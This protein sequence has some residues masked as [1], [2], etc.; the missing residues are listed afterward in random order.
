[1]A[2][3]HHVAQFRDSGLIKP[4][5]VAA[6]QGQDVRV[7]ARVADERVCRRQRA[8][9]FQGQAF[10]GTGGLD[11]I[12]GAGQGLTANQQAAQPRHCDVHVAGLC[13]LS[14]RARQSRSEKP[15]A[16]ACIRKGRAH[17][18][19]HRLEQTG[20]PANALRRPRLDILP[21]HGG[22][23]R[24]CAAGADSRDHRTAIDDGGRGE[25]A[26]GGPVHDIHGDM[27]G[28]SRICR[29]TRPDLIVTGDEGQCHALVGFRV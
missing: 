24:R 22:Q 27:G 8:D 10:G 28:A 21:Q 7:D 29:L 9:G 20:D 16:R 1:M 3:A 12:D 2:S 4:L 19:L 6:G 23:H 18:V 5:G 13:R 15:A 14:R 11:V 25:V 17:L 26:K